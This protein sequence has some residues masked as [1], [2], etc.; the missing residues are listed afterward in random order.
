MSN[1]LLKLKMEPV[2]RRQRRLRVLIGWAFCWILAAALGGLLILLRVTSNWA[3][4]GSIPLLGGLALAAAGWIWIKNWKT[5]DYQLLARIIEQKHPALRALLQTAVEQEPAGPGGKFN[6]LQ[7][8]LIEEAFVEGCRQNW[9]SSIPATRVLGGFLLQTACLVVLVFVLTELRGPGK[10]FAALAVR[11][12]AVSPGDASLERGSSLV[13]MARFPRHAPMEANL[14]IGAGPDLSGRLPLAK[15]LADPVFAS[16][17]LSVQSNF[18][19]RITYA[20]QSTRVFKVRVFENPKLER[21]NA[22]ITYPIYTGL[23]DKRIENTRRIS[24][25]EGSRLDWSFQLNKPVASAE[26]IAQDQTRIPLVFDPRLAGLAW[27]NH[28]VLANQSYRLL[29]KDSEGRTNHATDRLV[30]EVVKNR[31]AQI[32]LQA[33]QGDL[34]VSPV[35]EITFDGSVQDDFGVERFGVAYTIGGKPTQWLAAGEKVKALEKRAFKQVLFLEDLGLKPG[36]MLTYFAW[37]EDLGPDGQPRRA[38]SNLHF[39]EVRPFEEIFRQ[40]Q[41]QDNNQE[42][43]Q[44]QAGNENPSE[45]TE[46]LLDLQRQILQATWNLLQ[47]DVQEAKASTLEK[48][49]AVIQSSQEKALEQ[50]RSTQENAAN[51]VSQ[52]NLQQAETA[53]EKAA[54]TLKKARNAPK[55]L[56]DAI[57]FEQAAYQALLTT[58]ASE[59][60]VAQSRSRSQSQRGNRS[61][62][63]NSRQLQ[64]LDLARTENRYET[65]RQ[66]SAPQTAGQREES[67]LVRQLKELAQRQEDINSQLQELQTALQAARTENERAELRQRLKR[68]RENEEE[69]LDNMDQMAQRMAQQSTA[70]DRQQEIRQQMDQ[71]RDSVQKAAESL[72]QGK[73]QQALSAGARAQ[74]GLRQLGD[75]LR[76]NSA[77]QFSEQLR[78][79]RA[80]SQELSRQQAGLQQQLQEATQPAR[81]TLSNPAQGGELTKALEQQKNRWTNV[82]SQATQLTQSTE[83]AEPLLSQQLYDVLRQSNQEKV[84]ENLAFTQELVRRSFWNQ[85]SQFEQRAREGIE[86]FTRGI[87]RAADSVLGD[88]LQTLRA[89][90][91]ELDDL[92]RSLADD[93]ARE[94]SSSGTNLLADATSTNRL[95]SLPGPGSGGRTNLGSNRVASFSRSLTNGEPAGTNRLASLPGGG[96]SSRGRSPEMDRPGGS[97][98]GTGTNRADGARRLAASDSASRGGTNGPAS[99]LEDLINQSARPPGANG[100]GSGLLTGPDYVNWSERLRDVETMLDEPGLR[101]EIAGVRERARTM[102]TDYKRRGSPPQWPLVKSQLLGPLNEVRTRLSEELA[103]RDTRNPV[104]PLD[105]DPVPNQYAELVRQ[106]YERLGKEK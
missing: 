71:T 105:R 106:Y 27:T 86:Q 59:V 6:Y 73:P 64:Q 9:I 65:Q 90:S 12:V 3:W 18:S 36:Q 75:D 85:A 35:E 69:I 48:D 32:K 15:S 5:P 20:G 70:K 82:L 17:A 100:G 52:A 101:R 16:D 10:A 24:A 30:V 62:Q 46:R 51:P 4:P 63:R 26:L 50:L 66:A 88:E 95:T 61:G 2:A 28:P 44:S 67:E 77:G 91:R 7:E 14:E 8:C 23:K 89:A 42:S 83:A 22:T 25:V 21:A 102:R 11:E 41:A 34:R 76:R 43:Q 53:M 104:V 47:P 68:L 54:E 84:E 103:R 96:E 37:A 55:T 60:Q 38:C 87:N 13:I 31:A 99:G 19:Y 49:I 72:E 33:P 39:V 79:L 57:P 93:V 40:G 74:N 92:S 78:Q 56:E 80:D 94:Q 45:A 29:L 1:R 98:G 97:Q 81:P 58:Q